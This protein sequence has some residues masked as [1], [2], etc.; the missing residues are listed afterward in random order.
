[1]QPELLRRPQLPVREVR[2]NLDQRA[3][4]AIA[5]R[6]EHLVVEDDRAGG[7]DRLVRAAAPRKGKIDAAVRRIDRHQ[8]AGRR[9]RLA[10]GKHEDAPLAVD[11]GRNRRGVARPPLL[12]GPP[13]FASG[14][15]VEPDDA[16]T[17]RRADVH[18]EELAFNQRR[19]RA[20]RKNPEGRDTPCPGRA[21]R[22][23]FPVPRS[24]QC[25]CPCAPTVYTR[26]ASMTGLD[27]GPLL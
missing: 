25:S 7:V 20:C 6:D 15:L 24:R 23:R 13:D 19:R 26:A 27:R 5:R 14:R 22:S 10:S 17:A 8:P 3:S 4:G 12:A 2:P 18:D 21:S 9:I 1:M 16:R 11:H